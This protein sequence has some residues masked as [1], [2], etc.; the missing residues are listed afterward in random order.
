MLVERN[1]RHALMLGR[2]TMAVE[3]DY[4]VV[5]TVVCISDI[6]VKVIIVIRRQ[7]RFIFVVQ[8]YIINALTI[9]LGQNVFSTPVLWLALSE[10]DLFDRRNL[11]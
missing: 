9:T 3:G 1:V 5:K 8:L 11:K 6:Q 7:M 2:L 10:L 4:C